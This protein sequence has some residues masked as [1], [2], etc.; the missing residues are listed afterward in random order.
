MVQDENALKMPYAV[1]LQDIKTL[2]SSVDLLPMKDSGSFEVI[3]ID[4][5][6]L[7]IQAP[8][9][10]IAPGVLV[11]INAKLLIDGETIPFSATG[12]VISIAKTAQNNSKH[13]KIQLRQYDQDAWSKLV[14]AAADDQDRVDKL[15]SAMTGVDT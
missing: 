4:A 3:E 10:A 7:T 14:G 11:S 2:D 6:S 15:L 12:K 1:Q 5:Q 8:P 13:I 9:T